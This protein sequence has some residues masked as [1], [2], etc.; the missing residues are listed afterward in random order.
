MNYTLHYDNLIERAKN[1]SII[2][3]VYK[4]QHHIIPRCIGG[5]DSSENKVDLL[6]EEHLVA[7]LLLVKIYPDNKGL[8]KAASM[9]TNAIGKPRIRNNK[10]YS[11]VRTRY[12]DSMKGENNPMYGKK[13][14]N[15]GKTKETHPELYYDRH[16][17]G[18]TKKKISDS[19]KNRWDGLTYEERFGME[20]G[21]HLRE[22]RI[23]ELKLRWTTEEKIRMS[24]MF[25]GREF[26]DESKQKMKE[27]ARERAKTHKG[28][29]HHCYGMQHSDEKKKILSEKAK[30][31]EQ[32]ICPHC[33]KKGASS[34][35]K[36]WHF[37]MCKIKQTTLC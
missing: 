4:E 13:A 18:E 6:P 28:E 5:N 20:I 24:K 35:M 19:H 37:D 34:Q 31:R 36:R 7:H 2:P 15:S 12:S 3:L 22:C 32:L 33:G 30:N 1:R 29:N 11:W 14:W 17:S 23:N 25:K 21:K 16:Q 27:S 9:M 10:E 8:I 26:S